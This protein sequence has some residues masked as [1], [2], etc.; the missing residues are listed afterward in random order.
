MRLAVIV[1]VGFADCSVERRRVMRRITNGL[2]EGLNNKA[3]LATRQAYG[4]HSA[5]AVLAMIVLRCSGLDIRPA[6]KRL[7]A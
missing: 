3:R 1:T 5:A 4:F 6:H 2:V 7:A